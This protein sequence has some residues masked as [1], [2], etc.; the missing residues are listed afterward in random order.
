MAPEFLNKK[1]SSQL[2]T[3]FTWLLRN[4]TL[5]IFH[6]LYLLNIPS[7]LCWIVLLFLLKY[8]IGCPTKQSLEFFSLPILDS[9]YDFIQSCGFITTL[10][11]FSATNHFKKL[12][13][14]LSQ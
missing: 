3:F 5:L 9:E 8:W 14:V 2:S 13:Y 7:F 6:L 1:V 11:I 4:H 12:T 10:Y